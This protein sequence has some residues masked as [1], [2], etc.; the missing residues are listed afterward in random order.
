[1]AVKKGLVMK[2][3]NSFTCLNT[4]ACLLLVSCLHGTTT[5]HTGKHSVSLCFDLYG[6][7]HVVDNISSLATLRDEVY[8]R[9]GVP[10]ALQ[11]FSVNNK[12][13]L[14]DEALSQLAPYTSVNVTVPLLGGIEGPSMDFTDF[15]SKD[16]SSLTEFSTEADYWRTV[17][18]GFNIEGICKNPDCEAVKARGG[19]KAWVWTLFRKKATGEEISRFKGSIVAKSGELF[20]YFD[21]WDMRSNCVCQACKQ[22]IEPENIRRCGFYGCRYDIEG[23]KKSENTMSDVRDKKV[24]YGN[25]FMYFDKKCIP[26]NFIH[27]VVRKLSEEKNISVEVRALIEA[28]IDRKESTKTI[29]AM[30]NLGNHGAAIVQRVKQE[31]A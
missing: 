29:I 5:Q 18:P 15:S 19:R 31:M 12:M 6:K 8:D 16:T 20:D 2:K 27:I 21:M 11:R 25:K 17:H 24:E 4:L 14:S 13:V 9:T 1:M 10:Q 3:I 26:W 22:F 7:S 23:M 30:F 28:A